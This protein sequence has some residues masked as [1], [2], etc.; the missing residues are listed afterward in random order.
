MT[1]DYEKL[2]SVEKHKSMIERIQSEY[3]IHN[4]I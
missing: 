3:Y 2:E 1:N 4:Y